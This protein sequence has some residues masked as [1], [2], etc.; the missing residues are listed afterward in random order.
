MW[1]GLWAA[2]P[3]SLPRPVEW[4]PR[5][6]FWVREDRRR[7]QEVVG[8]VHMMVPGLVVVVVVVGAVLEVEE[9][10]VHTLVL[11]AVGVMEVWEVHT[12]TLEV[13]VVVRVEVGEHTQLAM[14]RSLLCDEFVWQAH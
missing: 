9:L 3:P 10:E 11:E 14:Q 12:L 5:K 7:V 13:K 2:A 1:S 4:Q 6:K 8:V